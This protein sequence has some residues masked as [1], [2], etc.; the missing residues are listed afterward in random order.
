MTDVQCC[1][2]VS[3]CAAMVAAAL[4]AD[5]FFSFMADPDDEGEGDA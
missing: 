4:S 2:L 3:L 5:E 1:L